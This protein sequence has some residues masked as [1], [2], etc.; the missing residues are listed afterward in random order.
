MLLVEEI[1]KAIVEDTLQ[2]VQGEHGAC[3]G[4]Q[5]NGG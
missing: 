5:G 3:G 2:E 4:C 1:I